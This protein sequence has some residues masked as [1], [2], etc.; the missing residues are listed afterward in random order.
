[1]ETGRRPIP[2]VAEPTE[3]GPQLF[4]ILALD[5]CFEPTQIFA[6]QIRGIRTFRENVGRRVICSIVGQ[7]K[8]FAFSI[9]HKAFI[10]GV[11]AKAILRIILAANH[12]AVLLNFFEL[13]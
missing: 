1:M 3:L 13:D 8:L 9:E 11:G 6:Y 12:I 10:P 5:V 7:P 4:I 2:W